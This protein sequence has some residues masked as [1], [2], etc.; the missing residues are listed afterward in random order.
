MRTSSL[1]RGSSARAPLAGMTKAERPVSIPSQPASCTNADLKAP[2]GAG[3][4]D[5]LFWGPR[6]IEKTKDASSISTN[7]IWVCVVCAGC[8]CILSVRM[9]ILR[10][11]RVY[12]KWNW[13]L[14][15]GAGELKAPKADTISLR[16]RRDVQVFAGIEKPILP[17]I[18]RTPRHC[19][20]SSWFHQGQA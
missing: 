12:L 9:Q 2:R 5:Q 16:L 17:V 18:T 13:H 4:K 1:I 11:W 19:P 20:Y 7:Y 6:R 15:L 14:R 10:P 3:D 8:P